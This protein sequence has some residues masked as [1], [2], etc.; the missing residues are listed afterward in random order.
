LE[1]ILASGYILWH[2]VNLVAIGCTP[3]LVH[4]VDKIWQ[5]WAKSHN[6]IFHNNR[7]KKNISSSIQDQTEGC[8]Q[9]DQ[10]GQIFTHC[11]ILY[12]WE[13]IRKLQK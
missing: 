7:E 9:G 6:R 2:F 10:I 1:Y 8:E 5:P 4:F 12:F 11:V 13:V 3:N